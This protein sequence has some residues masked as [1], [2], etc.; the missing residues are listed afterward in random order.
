MSVRIRKVITA[1]AEDG[2]AFSEVHREHLIGHAWHPV[3]P[4]SFASEDVAAWALQYGAQ[5]ESERDAIAAQL[6]TVEAAADA[7]L[8]KFLEQISALNDKIVELQNALPWDVRI[9]DATAF[10]AR[11]S[12]TELLDL[13]GSE[14]VARKQIVEMLLAYRANDWPI[15]LDS[16]ETQQAIS[17]LVECG[18]ISEER[19]AELLRD[20]SQAEAYKAGD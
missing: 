6:K 15:L 14:D 2:H 7:E 1:I 5:L 3:D 8:A 12:Q 9:I 20:S 16:P 17:Y 11:I 19:A 13:A 18:A 4:V 10:V